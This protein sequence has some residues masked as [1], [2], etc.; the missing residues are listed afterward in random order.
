MDICHPI[1]KASGAGKAFG[2][3]IESAISN[4]L[5]SFL[6]FSLAAISFILIIEF[7]YYRFSL[8]GL[9]VYSNSIQ[10]IYKLTRTDI[11][12][13]YYHLLYVIIASFIVCQ[14]LGM[15][16]SYFSSKKFIN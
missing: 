8:F 9:L 14:T 6:F 13:T 10:I 12:A 3:I 11:S 2:L 7:I 16:D 4:E 5:P 1:D 15:I